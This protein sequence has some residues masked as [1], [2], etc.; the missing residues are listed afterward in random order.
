VETVYQ[1]FDP[2]DLP[3]ATGIDYARLLDIAHQAELAQKV[4]YA[5]LATPSA[6]THPAEHGIDQPAL[7]LDR[8]GQVRS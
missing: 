7:T 8:D 1:V 4:N 5:A 2:F 6:D 3:P